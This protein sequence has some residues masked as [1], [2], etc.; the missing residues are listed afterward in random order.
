MRLTG[1][2]QLASDIMQES[3]TRMLEHY[4]TESLNVKLL[5]TIARN[6]I[7]DEVRKKAHRK[8]QIGDIEEQSI[9][10]EQQLLVREEYR[11]VM[12]AMQQLEATERDILALIVSSD[13]TYSDIAQ[14]T[15]ISESNVKVKVHRARLKIKK[16]LTL[17]EK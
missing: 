12:A 7:F 11:K 2:Y 14:V 1:D 9:D 15:G 4:G 10:L 3:F 5:F 13:L 8:E 16:I 17:G 6:G